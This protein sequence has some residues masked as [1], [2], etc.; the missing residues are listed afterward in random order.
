MALPTTFAALTTAT[1]AM[2]DN[3]FGAVGVLGV[4]GCTIAG[5]NSLTLTPA[6]NTPNGSY[7]NYRIYGGIA[8]NDNTSGVS[9]QVSALGFLPVYKDGPAG[10]VG[11]S[12]GEIQAGSYIQLI[13]DLALNAGA[14]GFHL[15]TPNAVAGL[16]LPLTGGTVSG[17]I[18]VTSTVI[19]N[20]LDTNNLVANISARAAT[21]TAS[22]LGNF[23]SALIGG[24]TPMLSVLSQSSALDFGD[25]VGGASLTLRSVALAGASIGDSVHLGL[26]ASVGIFPVS[27]QGYVVADNTIAVSA[28]NATGNTGLT[29]SP[30]PL[31]IRTT[32]MRF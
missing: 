12:G 20:E 25:L 11:L 9:A 3:N 31:T 17:P 19:A 24:G 6:A 13:Y 30:G 5:T 16:Y 14:G 8:V 26:P 15:M 27:F 21:V 2:L 18:V 32:A 1:G 7:V 4:T 29:V 23:A 22:T 10:P 28:I